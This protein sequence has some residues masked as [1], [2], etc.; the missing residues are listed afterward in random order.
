MKKLIL[1][2]EDDMQVQLRGAENELSGEAQILIDRIARK[3]GIRG[4]LVVS[5]DVDKRTID[6]K[7]KLFI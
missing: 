3:Y 2:F 7:I 4:T 1:G 6:M 5:K